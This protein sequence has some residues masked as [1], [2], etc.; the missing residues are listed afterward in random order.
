MDSTPINEI[1]DD[2]QNPPSVGFLTNSAEFKYLFEAEIDQVTLDQSK[3]MLELAVISGCITMHDAS[4]LLIA[5]LRKQAALAAPSNTSV[6]HGECSP[7]VNTVSNQS[8]LTAPQAATC[9]VEPSGAVM[10]VQNAPVN[11]MVGNAPLYNTDF[12]RCWPMD[13]PNPQCRG[14]TPDYRSN[15]YGNMPV[16][17]VI[18]KNRHRDAKAALTNLKFDGTNIPWEYF[19]DRFLSSIYLAG[20]L[21]TDAQRK[22][23]LLSCITGK[24]AWTVSSLPPN[25]TCQQLFES[26]HRRYS[27]VGE[28]YKYEAQLQSRKRDIQ[29]ETPQC[30]LDEIIY[31]CRKTYPNQSDYDM[32]QNIKKY[33]IMGHPMSYQL[34]INAS[35]NKYKCSIDDLIQACHQYEELELIRTAKPVVKKRKVRFL[36][37][38]PSNRPKIPAVICIYCHRPGHIFRDCLLLRTDFPDGNIDPELAQFLLREFMFG[39]NAEY[40][41]DF[42]FPGETKHHHPML[43]YHTAEILGKA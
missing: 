43:Q 3:S 10:S 38:P 28:E 25:A 34:H 13:L 26:L 35:V 16:E 27:A 8:R 6:T 19:A 42:N 21:W 5:K 37:V 14:D 18:D 32:D 39:S 11:A 40:E 7:V 22:M 41:Q 15:N 2:L 31:L 29:N 17:S 36:P 33:F 12:T 20:E 30:F 9:V 1:N 23:W 4:L 24:A